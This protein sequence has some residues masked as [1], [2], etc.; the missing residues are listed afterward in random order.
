MEPNP[1]EAADEASPSEPGDSTSP[2]QEAS[3]EHKRSESQS[4]DYENR[5]RKLTEGRSRSS[6][7]VLN[8]G[9]KP[10]KAMVGGTGEPLEKNEV[11]YISDILKVWKLPDMV[12]PFSFK[13]L[14][15]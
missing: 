4:S 15:L 2:R 7:G 8:V 13:V 14:G 1:N 10:N 9:M 12:V 11:Y 3:G 5:I 6:R